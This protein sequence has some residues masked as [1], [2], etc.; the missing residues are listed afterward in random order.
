MS[1]FAELMA[2]DRRLAILRFLSE[3]AD[4]SLNTSILQ[5]C[6][7]AIGHGV[8]RDQVATD[9]AWLEEQGLVALDQ[10]GNVSVVKLSSRGADVASG[11]GRVPGVKRPQ[12]G[13]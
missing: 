1:N 3:D 12:P 8:S 6:L 9:C 13:A 2:A 11:R 10:V 4:Y 5:D 7:A